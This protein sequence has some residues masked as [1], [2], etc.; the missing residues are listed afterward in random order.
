MPDR[1]DFDASRRRMLVL[2]GGVAA[3]CALPVGLARAQ[4]AKTTKEAAQYQDAPKGDQQ[5]LK[6]QFFQPGDG[7][8]GTCQLVQG[9]ISASG[10]CTLFTAKAQ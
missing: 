3:A 6:C 7:A 2:A 1:N 10:W 5:C 9:D 4:G 8:K